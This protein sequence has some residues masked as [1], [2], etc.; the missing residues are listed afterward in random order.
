[1]NIKRLSL[2]LLACFL[3]FVLIGN[4]IGVIYALELIQENMEKQAM[5]SW[6]LYVGKAK[7][8]LSIQERYFLE[9][10]IR[11]LEVQLKTLRRKS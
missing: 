3:C 4:L 6:Y 9:K 8:R 11:Y 5:L 1:M 7:N 2:T 10:N